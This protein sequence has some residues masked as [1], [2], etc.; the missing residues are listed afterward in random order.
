MNLKKVFMS[1]ALCLAILSG[2]SI[3]ASARTIDNNTVKPALPGYGGAVGRIQTTY[4][5]RV[6]VRRGPGTNY[7]T[8]G[9]LATG[10]SVDLMGANYQ[11]DWI[12]L[13][14]NVDGTS[15]QKLGW[16]YGDYVLNLSDA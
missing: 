6:N 4:G 5:G 16:V 3:S 12:Y 14:Y 10:E 1:F 15:N 7:S 13:K 8:I 11:G 9:S 2:F